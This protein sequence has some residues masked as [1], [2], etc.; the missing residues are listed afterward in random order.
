MD[1][2][3]ADV[4]QGLKRWGQSCLQHND[5]A[6]NNLGAIECPRARTREH[7]LVLSSKRCGSSPFRA[8]MN[9]GECF[10]LLV[11][12]AVVCRSCHP[13]AQFLAKHGK[14]TNHRGEW[15]GPL[16]TRA[17]FCV[18]CEQRGNVGI[19]L[20]RRD[21]VR[22]WQTGLAVRALHTQERKRGHRANPWA[23]GGTAQGKTCPVTNK[24]SLSSGGSEDH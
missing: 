2:I 4:D 18:P 15:M 11:G 5:G 6:T 24:R 3:D 7:R 12:D 1:V 9:S 10:K 23:S 8:S 19:G 14:L 20:A 16:W 21:K 17:I 13:F 22:L